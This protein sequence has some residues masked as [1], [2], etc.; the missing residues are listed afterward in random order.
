MSYARVIVN[1]SHENLDKFY[2]YEIP[3]EWE[4]TI[5]VGSQV[6]IPFG[7]GNKLIK[8]FVLGITEGS[9]FDPAKIKPLKEVLQDGMV[10]ESQFI[11]LASWIRNRYG[12]TMN[13]ALRAVLPVKRKMKEKEVRYLH[14]QASMER[15]ERFRAECERKKY[16]ARLLLAE[17]LMDC[18]EI[19][20]GDAIKNYG[21]SR[22][23]IKAFEQMG[24]LSISSERTY[25]NPVETRVCEERKVTLTESQK[26]IVEDIWKEYEDGVRNTYL[27]HG[28]TGSGKTE[29]YM[30][31]ME[32]VV[33][34][35]KQ[36]I[37][38]IPEIALT[39]PMVE[40]FYQR[41]GDSI[42]VLH[43]KLSDGERSDQYER[44][45]NGEISIMI[46]PRSAL[47]TP[48]SNI[49]LIILDEEHEPSFVNENQPKYHAREVAIYRAEMCGASVVLG[50]AT[51][52]LESYYVAKQGI[53][54]LYELKERVGDSQLPNVTVID[55]REEL[56]ARNR[57]IFSRYLSQRINE[58]LEQ[59][60]QILLFINRRGYAGFI[61]C[62]ACGHVLK[63]PHCDVSLTE[64]NNGKL[65]CHYCG[66][67]VVKPSV[68]P[69]CGSKY[70][71][72]FGV[73]TQK[74]EEMARKEFPNAR[75]LRMDGDTV[76]KKGEYEKILNQFNAGFAD[77]LIGTQ[78]V[79]KGHDF[80][81]VSLVGAMAA[82]LSLHMNDFRSAERTFQ[83]LSQAGGRAGRRK[84]QGEFIIQTYD[85][86]HY[87]IVMTKDADY[88]GFYEKE[89][90]YR[91]LLNYPPL[92]HV[93]AIM[94]SSK[95]QE[96][97]DRTARLLALAVKDKFPQIQLIGPVNATIYKL[98]D[99]YR[100]VMYL[101]SAD[102]EQLIEGKNFL[103]EYIHFSEQFKYVTVSFDMDPMNGY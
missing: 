22:E 32:R 15:M 23:A 71:G 79:A 39:V 24:I 101:K 25:R 45:K 77:I 61:S 6:L 91:G 59:K 73:G 47:F 69:S 72:S 80:E 75:I 93:L 64:H 44:A 74:V 27:I 2:E 53:Y 58:C 55:L 3:K 81:N 50:S 99:R 42:S 29:V 4:E 60:K 5:Q 10:L 19:E 16:K 51:P 49:G 18:P 11:Q 56:K 97:P 1:I 43:S 33:R 62:R 52:S 67:E 95:Y 82:D 98:N 12:A 68:C 65:M 57:S 17:T 94:V 21:V 63:C 83:L 92:G 86:K 41:F 14:L 31:L 85:P 88:Q 13:D 40:R 7:A 8:G 20:I 46:G 76:S 48:F 66:Y 9:Q 30:E 87:S 100:K 96:R 102:L 70:I 36:V 103:E 38:L 89:M 54:K 35:G 34:E 90:A 28:V 78:M 26:N 37:F 84:K